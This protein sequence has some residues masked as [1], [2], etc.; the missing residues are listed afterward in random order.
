M[1]EWGS[2]LPTLVSGSPEPELTLGLL[3]LNPVPF[4]KKWRTETRG[5]CEVKSRGLPGHRKGM[6]LGG[7]EVGLEHWQL[8]RTF[9]E[10]VGG[11]QLPVILS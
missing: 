1:R 10:E 8:S 7:Q 9:L 5:P 4:P 3:A 6:G 11:C 2:H